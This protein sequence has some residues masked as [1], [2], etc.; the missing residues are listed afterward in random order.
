MANAL[1]PREVLNAL[2]LRSPWVRRREWPRYGIPRGYGS[3]PEEDIERYREW[4]ERR[5]D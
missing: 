3:L 1:L 4:M 2:S 5:R